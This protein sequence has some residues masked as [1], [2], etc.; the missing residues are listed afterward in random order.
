MSSPDFLHKDAKT[1]LCEH[2]LAVGALCSLSTN[3]EE[4][5]QAARESFVRVESPQSAVDFHLRFW[6]D[7][8]AISEPPWPKPYVRGL[9][10][11]IFAG[12][13]PGNSMLADLCERRVIG[14]FSASMSAD[15]KYWRTV[16]FPI[17]LTIVSASVGVAELHG[18]C[19]ATD[20]Y[21]IL[22]AGPSGSGKSTLATAL[23]RRGF[24]FLS[25]DRT[26]CSLHNNEV[27][28]W[29][30]STPLKLRAEAALWFHELQSE[31]PGRV[32][33]GEP[34]FWLDP[35]DQ[36]GLKRIRCC[37]VRSLVFLERGA[38]SHCN[39]SR[40]TSVEA[41]NRLSADLMPELPEAAAK[42]S[43]TL[44]RLVESPCWLLRYGS[45]PSETVRSIMEHL[46][47]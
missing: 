46:A 12:F 47:V 21:G 45:E 8:A 7:H 36:L 25:D 32:H 23:C 4:L 11:L 24:S 2:Y 31:Q 40:I 3:C 41:Q 10:H 1:D 17:L 28:G 22:L 20:Q 39:W 44:A 43:D 35:V 5:L 6:V 37:P 18:A 33:S 29:G 19:V 16:I 30:L 14:R 38:Y 34:A 13:A 26:F 15:A 42:R 9:D 27:L